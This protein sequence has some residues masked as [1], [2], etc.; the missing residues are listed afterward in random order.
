LGQSPNTSST[1]TLDCDEQ[2]SGHVLLYAA[3]AGLCYFAGINCL[4]KI[5]RKNRDNRC[6]L[7]RTNIGRIKRTTTEA[8]NM[9]LNETKSLLKSVT[10]WLLLPDHSLM[11]T[12]TEKILYAPGITPDPL[13]ATYKTL[14]RGT[15]KGISKCPTGQN[16]AF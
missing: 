7:T 5:I 2:L 6:I 13:G 8:S 10:R 16:K 3:I 4:G 11:H 14:S 15:I 9:G 12:V 1:I